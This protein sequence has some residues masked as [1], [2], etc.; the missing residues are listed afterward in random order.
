MNK[1]FIARMGTL[2]F[3]STNIKIYLA[4]NKPIPNT[5]ICYYDKSL[6]E[7]KPTSF[8]GFQICTHMYN[9]ESMFLKFKL[10][11]HGSSGNA[12]CRLVQSVLSFRLLSINKKIKIYATI[13]LP[14]FL[15]G[16]ESSSFTLRGVYSLG[17]CANRAERHVT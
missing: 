14:V 16:C 8:S 5:N 7:A 12:C 9:T 1:L 10:L 4:N 13:T 15:Y 11:V 2:K 3:Y 17:T 6:H